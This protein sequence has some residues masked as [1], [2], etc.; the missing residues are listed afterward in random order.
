LSAVDPAPAAPRPAPR[1]RLPA[2]EGLT[3]WA[4]AL[5]AALATAWLT[6]RSLQLAC[7]FT[8]V[9]L[10]IGLYVRDRRAGLVAMWL[11]WLVTPF[12]RR[13][14]LLD[15]PLQ[16]AEPLAV[17]PFLETAAIVALELSQIELTR[18]VKRLLILATAGYLLGLP[19]G[20]LTG[21]KAAVFAT[22]AYLTA[23]G[24]FVIGY[25]EGAGE[26]PVLPSVLMVAGPAMAIYAFRQYYLPLPRW[27]LVWLHS[28]DINS[29]GAP[30]N[31]HIRVW[32]TLNSPGTFAGVLGVA[33]LCLL[34]WRRVT[35]PKLAGAAAVLGAL[36]L[37]YVRS[38]W[39]GIAVTAIAVA[40]VTRGAALKQLVPVIVLL[41][42]ATP[43]VLGG[44]T[45]A[46][47]G[48][49]FNSFGALGTDK[50]AQDRS[51][52]TRTVF[53]GAIVAP[54]GHGLGAA[55]E[56]SR[57]N[58]SDPAFRYTDNGY[59]SLLVQVGPIGFIVVM[60]VFLSAIGAGWRNAWRRPDNSNDVLAFG[61]LV[62][63]G[64]LM[65]AGDELYGITGM[66][67]WYTAGLAVRRRVRHK[68]VLA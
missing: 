59:L 58:S 54:L 18:R 65:F 1:S 63:L 29:A 7:T 48:D 49:R 13:I 19:A 33:A 39:L 56:P 40:A 20:L 26:R 21:P 32:S 60:S 55:G 35:L 9:V 34:I 46:A 4:L 57:L 52:T 6:L 22:L 23:L 12:L 47:L 28:S 3:W 43:L 50:S 17:A 45:R 14:F 11:I 25:R 5:V 30:E 10:T 44:S 64:V 8:M 68:E 15:E 37:T 36:A 31:G 61:V 66:I 27:D 24:C 42:L 67:F 53:G 62:L 41:V 2:F 38:A 16:A 51:T